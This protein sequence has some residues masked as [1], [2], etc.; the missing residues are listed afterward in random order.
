M[1][2]DQDADL[3][4]VARIERAARA[5]ANL[6]F[7][8]ECRVAGLTPSEEL[9]NDA[10]VGRFAQ[11]YEYAIRLRAGRLKQIRERPT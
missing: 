5:A 7:A 3:A 6:R 8:I 9:K 10:G 11:L 4:A 2:P 1:T